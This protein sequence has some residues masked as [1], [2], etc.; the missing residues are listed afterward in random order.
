MTRSESGRSE[1]RRQRTAFARVP[2]LCLGLVLASLAP[3]ACGDGGGDPG[4]GASDALSGPDRPLEWPTREVFRIGGVDAPAWAAFGDP[5]D[6]AFDAAGQ[7]YVLD[8]TAGQVVVVDTAGSLVRTVGR[9]GEGPDE[10]RFPGRMAVRPDGSLFV[11]DAGHGALLHFATD[12]TFVEQVPLEEGG[13]RPAG[14]LV[15]AGEALL[16]EVAPRERDGGTGVP[17]GPRLVVALPVERGDSAATR[18]A[19]WRPPVPVGRA[20]TEEETGGFRVRLPPVVGFPPSLHLAG[21][22]GGAMALADST[23]WTVRVLGNDGTPIAILERPGVPAG[24]TGDLRESEKDRR[25]DAL[26]ANPPRM[27][28]NQRGG[29]SQSVANE[30]V[31]RLERARI[32][33]MGFHDEVPV[34]QRLATDPRGRIWVERFSGTPGQPGP[35]DVVLPP[36]APDGSP[37]RYLGTLPPGRIEFPEAFGPDGLVAVISQDPLGAPVIRVERVVESPPPR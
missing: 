29:G 11:Y 5:V 2:A 37:A 25:L 6:V 8:A 18:Y 34:I 23:T 16:A 15:A 33:A 32:D 26:E 27:M 28:V 14:D 30:A 21:L 9:E 1:G 36:T 35:V 31:L 22:P 4:A 13:L 24:V 20:L 7:L 17:P 10:F 19:G 12:G 3:V